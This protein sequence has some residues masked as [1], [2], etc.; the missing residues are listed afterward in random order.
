[1]AIRRRRGNGSIECGGYINNGF[2][3]IASVVWERRFGDRG[4][5][6]FVFGV[7][8]VADSVVRG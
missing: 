1:M 3:W 5:C 6:V 4:D 2:A 8:V 7:E